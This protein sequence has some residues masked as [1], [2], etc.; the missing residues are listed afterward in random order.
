MSTTPSGNVRALNE[1]CIVECIVVDPKESGWF[2]ATPNGKDYIRIPLHVVGEDGRHTGEFI[3]W[4][5]WLNTDENVDRTAARLKEVFGFNGDFVSLNNGRISLVGLPC[6]IETEMETYEG[7]QKCRIKWLN[8]PGGLPKKDP[9]EPAKLQGLLAKITGRAKAI[10]TKTPSLTTGA[11]AA[12]P[13]APAHPPAT[14]QPSLPGTSPAA[15]GDDGPP[16]ED[17]DVPF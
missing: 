16:P 8:P 10:A 6:Q 12:R 17:D 15:V 3:S 4:F 13:S 1:A 9:M 14:S 7:K 5:G 11:P 2:N